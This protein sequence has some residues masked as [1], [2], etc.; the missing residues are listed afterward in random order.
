MSKLYWSLPLLLAF[1]W[2]DPVDVTKFMINY[3]KKSYFR[4]YAVKK[5]MNME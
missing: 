2:L 4:L 5:L 1:S 3:G